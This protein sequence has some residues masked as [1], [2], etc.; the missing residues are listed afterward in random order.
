[1]V[2]RKDPLLPIRGAT[3]GLFQGVPNGGERKSGGVGIVDPDDC[4]HDGELRRRRKHDL[5]AE[6]RHRHGYGVDQR[7]T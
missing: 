6:Q 5:H 4:E 3:N 2:W 7:S 1:V